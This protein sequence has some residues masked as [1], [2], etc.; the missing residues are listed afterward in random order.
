MGSAEIGPLVA[1]IQFTHEKCRI[2]AIVYVTKQMEKPTNPMGY[3]PEEVSS[4]MIDAGTSALWPCEVPAWED[5]EAVV[6]RVY[7][8]MVRA[9]LASGE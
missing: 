9:A 3:E 1:S 2:L 8:A 6:R 7:E 4:Q 5:P